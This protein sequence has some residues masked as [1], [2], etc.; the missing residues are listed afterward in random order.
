MRYPEMFIIYDV[1]DLTQRVV[2]VVENSNDIHYYHTSFK[3]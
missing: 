1:F 2:P 3:F